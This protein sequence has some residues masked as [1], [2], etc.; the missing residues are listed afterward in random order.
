MRFLHTSDWHIGRTVKGQSRR[1]E[2]EAALA[3][4]LEHAREQNVDCL[5]VAGDVF[6]S[7]A[8]PPEA[9]RTV[10]GFFRELHGAGIP[11]VVIAGNHDHPVRF[12]ALSRLLGALDIH[13]V[14]APRAPQNGGVI[15]IPSRDASETA[16]VAALPWIEQRQAVDF[17][18]LQA[19]QGAPLAAYAE[20]VRE[21]MAILAGSFRPD[22]VNVLLS[23]VLLNNAVVGKTGGERE[24]HL[25]M[26]I[27]GVNPQMLP[28][29]AQYIAL[30]HVHKPQAPR[31][32]PAVHYSGSLL[33]LDFG[34]VDQDKSVNLVEVHPRRPAEVTPLPITAGKKLYDIGVEQKGINLSELP[35]Y[36]AMYPPDAAWL[37]V[38]VDVDVPV[39]NLTGL[40]K[41]KL[42]NAVIVQRVRSMDGAT[43]G[44]QTAGM[45]PEDLFRAF[46]RSKLGRGR[47][48]SDET[49]KLFR[50]LLEEESRETASS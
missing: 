40:V 43:E 15:E 36:A 34:E 26:G 38:F 41:E 47:E 35:V 17:E 20:R 42:P 22:T 32:S 6:D 13:L 27:Y 19:G 44:P 49:M 3:Q 29:S 28:T 2:Q 50:D 31:K 46:Y 1:E 33:Q 8:P 48:A 9:E 14:G 24:L 4:V 16:L 5:L 23:H 18:Q 10:Y 39:A 25:D 21:V 45:G 12:D 37:R 7:S 11:A 30:G